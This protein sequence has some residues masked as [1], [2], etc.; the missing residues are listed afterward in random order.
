MN[1]I[2]YFHCIFSADEDQLVI[3]QGDIILTYEELLEIQGIE[4]EDAQSLLDRSKR[5]AGS[6][7]TLLEEGESPQRIYNKLWPNCRVPY[8]VDPYL[9]KY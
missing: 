2:D 4:P 1:P 9:S 6:G 7:E 3:F 8:R 5:L